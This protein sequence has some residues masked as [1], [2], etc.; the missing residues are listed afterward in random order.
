[1]GVMWR[2]GLTVYTTGSRILGRA[3]YNVCRPVPGAPAVFMAAKDCAERT[4]A[5]IV[6]VVCDEE[7]ANRASE[8]LPFCAGLGLTP[9]P[10]LPRRLVF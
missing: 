9:S 6:V 1:M 7:G 2:H 3:V 10:L 4:A 5:V 8:R